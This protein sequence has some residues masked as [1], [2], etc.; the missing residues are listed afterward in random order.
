MREQCGIAERSRINKHQPKFHFSITSLRD[1]R[2]LYRRVNA[3]E[4]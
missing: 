4:K 1:A 3:D 2:L